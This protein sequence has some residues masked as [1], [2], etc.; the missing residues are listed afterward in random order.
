MQKQQNI[1]FL[2]MLFIQKLQDNSHL[3]VM[4]LSLDGNFHKFSSHVQI[5]T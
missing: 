2:L 5:S 3:T 1:A 4:L